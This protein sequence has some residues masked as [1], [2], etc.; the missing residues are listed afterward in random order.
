[1]ALPVCLGCLVLAGHRFLYCF[2]A[3]RYCNDPFGPLRRKKKTSR[4]RDG[5]EKNYCARTQSYGGQFRM[6][7]SSGVGRPLRSGNPAAVYGPF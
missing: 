6:R 1:M 5:R 4:K 2:I 3:P 7:P